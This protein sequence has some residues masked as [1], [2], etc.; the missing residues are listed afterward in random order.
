M[1]SKPKLS[2]LTRPI[3]AGAMPNLS[4]SNHR[5]QFIPAR[6]SRNRRVPGLYVRG[7]RYYAQLWVDVGNGKKAPRRF[8]LKDGDNQPVRILQEARE[9]LEIKRHERREKQLPGVG[10]KPLFAD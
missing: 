1:Q 5:A 10:R 4:A 6:D 9:A 3:N 2:R 7:G 8:P